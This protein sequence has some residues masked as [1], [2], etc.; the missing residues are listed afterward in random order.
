MSTESTHPSVE[1]EFAEAF[2]KAK[3]S[4]RYHLEL[5]VLEL[6]EA[7][8][9]EM[10][11]QGIS[12]TELA[13]R[14]DVSRAYVTQFLKGKHNTQL[15]TIFKIA[16]AV[17][18]RPRIDLRPADFREDWLA[19]MMKTNE[20][21]QKAWSRRAQARLPGKMTLFLRDSWSQ[22]KVEPSHFVW[23]FPSR[24]KKEIGLACTIVR[25][26]GHKEEHEEALQVKA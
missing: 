22:L 14:L 23:T 12:R 4:W 17:G 16:D 19:V 3:R 8:A 21:L 5:C 10:D 25:T 7:V 26:Y 15:S 2:V 6:T 11:A 13:Q 1:D 9:R 18:L 24:G 20:S